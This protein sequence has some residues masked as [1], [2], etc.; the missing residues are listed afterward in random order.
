MRILAVCL[1]GL[2]FATPLIAAEDTPTRF[3]V[4]LFGIKVGEITL[5]GR[6]RNG[7]YVAKSLFRTTGMTGRLARARFTLNAKGRATKTGLVPRAYSEDIDTGRRASSARLAYSGGVP[8][9]TGGTLSGKTDLLDPT[10][11]KGTLDPM[12]VLFAVLRDQP[13]D[14]L[15][16][17]TA[18]VFDGARRSNIRLT[19]RQDKNGDVICSGEYRRV[20]GFSERELTR[21]TAFPLRVTYRDARGVMQAIRIDL[22]TT[23]GKVVML[24]R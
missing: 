24:R 22:R 13:D 12:T 1:W 21:Q 7:A 3:D 2:M 19:S 6:I 5:A 14:A 18:T 8:R 9:V 16:T 23:Y 15:C 4:R 17:F 20:A 10:Q 11:E